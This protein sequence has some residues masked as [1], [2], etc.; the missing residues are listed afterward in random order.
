MKKIIYRLILSVAFMCVIYLSSAQKTMIY[1]EPGVKFRLG[2]E[3]FNKEKYGAAQKCF[4][5]VIEKVSNPQSELSINSEYYSAICAIYLFNDDAEYLLLNFIKK[6]P[7]SSKIKYAYFEL[8]KFYYTKK[9]YDKVIKAFD[10]ID[11]RDLNEEELA[12]YYFKTGYSYFSLENYDKAQT[13]FFEIKDID[14]K[15]TKPANY[16]YGHIEYSKKNY[17]T[18]LNCFKKLT[19]DESFG[20]IVLYYIAQIYYVQEKYDELLQVAPPLLNVATTKRAPEIARLIG[21]A[22]YRTSRYSEAI[23]Y[24]EMY[25]E[26]TPNTITRD[27]LYELGYAYYKTDNFI[28]AIETLQKVTYEDDALSQNAYY[29]IADSYLKGN[30]KHYARNS[31][32]YAY[33]LPFDKDIQEDALYNYAKLS[34]ELSY[35]PYNE[36]IKAFQSYIN[37]YPQS[38]RINEAYTYLAN[39]FLTTKNYKDALASIEKIKD[40]DD[41]LKSAYQKITYFRGLELFNAKESDF[42]GA[43]KLFDLSMQ[44]NINDVIYAEANYWKAEAF[45]RLGNF[46][47]AVEIYNKFLLTPSAYSLPIYNSAYYNIGYAYFKEKKYNDAATSF[48]SFLR[49]PGDN[50]ITADASLRLA[51][52]YFISK[53]Y[54]N[55]IIYYDKSI[56]LKVVDSDYALFQK[57]LALGVTGKFE[58]KISVLQGLLKDYPETSYNDDAEFE[59]AG[60]YLVLGNNEEALK[61]FNKVVGD[62][63]SSSYIKKSYLKT[64]LIYYEK[65]DYEQA[66]NTLKKVVSD[67]PASDESKQ[68]L[69]S[70]KNIYK[71]MGKP[72]DYFAY[73]KNIPFAD[74][75]NAEQDSMSFQ[76]AEDI[77]MKGDCENAVKE[78]TKYIEKYPQ[79]SFIVPANY[80]KAECEYKN[81]NTAEALKGYDFVVNSPKT[82]FT[83]NALAKASYMYYNNKDYSKALTY[84]E[85]LESIAEYKN[86]IIVARIGMMRSNYLLNDYRKTIISSGKLLETDKI[87]N[88]VIQEAHLKAGLSALEIDSLDLAR[89]E[90]EAAEKMSKNE[91]QAEA[92]Y[93]L[94]KVKY[95]LGD[96]TSC[97]NI[98]FELINSVP[99]YDYWIAKSLILLSDNYVKTGNVFQAKQT[100]QSIIE[101]YEGEDLVKIAK[102]KLD[103]IIES[104][105]IIEQNNQQEEIEIKSEGNTPED[106]K[107]FESDENKFIGNDSPV[108]I[109]VPGIQ[110]EK[111]NNINEQK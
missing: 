60:A 95:L 58:N 75:S 111:T 6:Y 105:K 71:D 8:A 107:L 77:Y 40:K 68:A 73:A 98:I 15:Y 55:A 45:Y 65:S 94:A 66:L 93:N 7:Y 33:K 57:A 22:Y 91:M 17:E 27:D 1:N 99:S 59:M 30:E 18:A 28:K 79:G 48:R 25:Q 13:A 4:T 62:Y 20:P 37:E 87:S 26:K 86:N 42:E 64:G 102:E 50:D 76:V 88:E 19:Q 69:A 53:E 39:I 51:D 23:S 97:E 82:S 10:N 46:S 70:I 89:K 78:F 84:Y 106:N 49:R 61:Y 67:Y 81:N 21:E 16:F 3:L 74:I 80:Y 110:E 109:P 54:E 83:E 56:E 101:N 5:D 35:N 38:T 31:F 108:N 41:K 90:L 24:L 14:T 9:K 96:F 103:V 12:E 63:P 100:L 43:I 85:K 32:L 44:Y 104:Q 92:K 52:C 34:Y 72:D 29:H 47:T 11:I 36:A 2:M